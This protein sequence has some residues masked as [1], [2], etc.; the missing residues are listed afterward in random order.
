MNELDRAMNAYESALRH[1]PYSV[2]ALTQIAALCRAREQYGKVRP[3]LFFKNSVYLQLNLYI[4]IC[5]YIFL[6]LVTI[7]MLV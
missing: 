4:C 3:F 2:A 7:I 5:T 1:N 6:F